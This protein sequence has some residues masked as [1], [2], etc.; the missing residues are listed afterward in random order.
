VEGVTASLGGG[1][2]QGHSFIGEKLGVTTF[3]PQGERKWGT[4][5]S[6]TAQ[7]CSKIA[8]VWIHFELNLGTFAIFYNFTF[9]GN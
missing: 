5:G 7:K 6:Q 3:F 4:Y 9:T 8:T 1:G 2:A